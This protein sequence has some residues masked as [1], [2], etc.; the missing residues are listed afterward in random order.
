M[1]GNLHINIGVV[2]WRWSFEKSREELGMSEKTSDS[3]EYQD[4]SLSE[5]GYQ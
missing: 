2:G 5:L 4:N 3:L 1:G